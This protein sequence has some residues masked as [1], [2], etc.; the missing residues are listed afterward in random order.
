MKKLITLALALALSLFLLT[1]C[2]SN[3]NGNS[4]STG[5]NS[6]TPGTS[7]GGN[8]AAPSG[9][10][11]KSQGG[12]L[13][14]ITDEQINC[15]KINNDGTQS[16]ITGEQRTKM[17]AAIPAEMKKGIGELSI[18]NVQEN[19]IT[20]AGYIA[21]LVF[22]VSSKEAYIKLTDY[23]KS[24]GGTVTK[25]TNIGEALYLEIDFAWGKLSQCEYGDVTKEISVSFTIN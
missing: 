1:A 16:V 24:L 17:L 15:Y 21:G 22:K 3:G 12:E 9:T 13:F 6:S 8:D 18:G 5:G 7:Q 2:G 25:D 20:G 11:G 14:G 10:P 19:T 23:Y 4:G